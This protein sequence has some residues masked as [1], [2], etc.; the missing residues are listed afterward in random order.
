MTEQ[1]LLNRMLESF[2]FSGDAVKTTSYADDSITA[3]NGFVVEKNI[4]ITASS[5]RYML[6]DYSKYSIT[7]SWQSGR[8]FIFPPSMNTSL[9]SIIVE[10]YRDT[11]YTT[12]SVFSSTNPNTL[13]PKT[14][15][16]TE[17]S[18]DPVAGSVGDLVLEYVVGVEGTNQSS[19]G[20]TAQGL[21]FFI[22]SNTDKTLVKFTNNENSDAILHYGQL[23]FE[24]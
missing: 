19:G 21:S 4:N 6:I 1:I 22:R 5:S 17:W 15:S 10:V 24:I 12:G 3:G 7:E 8:V 2:S 11:T 20:G 9:G 16:G 14:E 23:F 13:A 18:L